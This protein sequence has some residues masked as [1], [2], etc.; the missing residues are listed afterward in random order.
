VRNTLRKIVGKHSVAELRRLLFL[1]ALF[2]TLLIAAVGCGKSQSGETDANTDAT[3]A[4]EQTVDQSA[5]EISDQTA[6]SEADKP[7]GKAKHSHAEEESDPGEPSAKTVEIPSGVELVIELDETLE[8]GQTQTG[9]KF[10]ATLVDALV[11][12]NEIVF[13]AGA[14][15]T[16]FVEKAVGSGRLKTD[17]ELVLTI[18]EI[19]GVSIKTDAIEDKAASHADRNKKLIGGGAIV[20]G[21]IGAI[22]GKDVKGAIIGAAAGAAAGTGAAIL[23][24]K[25][26]LK[27]E[28]GTLIQFT[29]TEPVT[30]EIE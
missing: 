9:D 13:S 21:I 26:N 23:T 12:S 10:S 28:S 18:V 15:V 11:I 22:K 25:K 5:D 4:E 1:S 16:G 24:G 6:D 29:L 30:V 14:P 7:A 8:T 19:D 17:A 20:G 3:S 27:Y 2:S